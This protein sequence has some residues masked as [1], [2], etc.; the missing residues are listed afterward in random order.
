MHQQ[1]CK[2]CFW[3]ASATAETQSRADSAH[4]PSQRRLRGA[5]SPNHSVSRA[6][7][8]CSQCTIELCIPRANWRLRVFSHPRKWQAGVQ[9]SPFKMI[10]NAQRRRS[11]PHGSDSASPRR[12]SPTWCRRTRLLET[13]R[14]ERIECCCTCPG[15]R[16]GMSTYAVRAAAR[17]PPRPCAR[18][19]RFPAP[20]HPD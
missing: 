9:I 7:S 18:R 14:T 6:G 12:C 5:P 2:R 8:S 1:G 10:P 17:C 3:H 19:D 11:A 13:L 15:S 16:I 4:F 20:I